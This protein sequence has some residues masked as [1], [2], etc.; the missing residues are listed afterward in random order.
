MS[1]MIKKGHKRFLISFDSDLKDLITF[2]NHIFRRD[3]F[4]RLKHFPSSFIN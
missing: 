3:K 4:K 2:I 1:I